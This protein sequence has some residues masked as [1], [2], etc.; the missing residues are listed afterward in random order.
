MDGAEEEINIQKQREKIDALNKEIVARIEERVRVAKA[1]GEIKTEQELPIHQPKREKEVLR[2]CRQR[3]KQVD[4][5]PEL[6]EA[7]FKKII[8]L[9]R[10]AQLKAPYGDN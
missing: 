7:I 10:N 4:L 8:E 1:L 3:A 6:I 2:R 9:S 5:N